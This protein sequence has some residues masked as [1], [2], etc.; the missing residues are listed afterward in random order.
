MLIQSIDKTI[1]VALCT[2]SV[3]LCETF[4][5]LITQSYTEMTQSSIENSQRITERNPSKNQTR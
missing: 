2:P 1:S 3:V 4:K 5:D